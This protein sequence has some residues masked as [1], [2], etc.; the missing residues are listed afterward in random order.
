MAKKRAKCEGCGPKAFFTSCGSVWACDNCG[1]EKPRRFRSPP[2]ESSPLTAAQLAAIT[3]V[4]LH[5]MRDETE[6]KS[7]SV[8]NHGRTAIVVV[9]VG[10][11]GDEGTLAASL[12]RD[13]GIFRIG[14]GGRIEATSKNPKA[15]KYPL[16]YG[17]TH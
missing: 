6:V 15:K 2:T 17:W 14:R 1:A 4:Q 7:F 10:R 3:K 11:V 12:C 5:K 8:S 9:V 16:I 13:I